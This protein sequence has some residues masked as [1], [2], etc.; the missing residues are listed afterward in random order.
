MCFTLQGELAIW[1]WLSCL[2]QL[3]PTKFYGLFLLFLSRGRL[4]Y[5]WY[6]CLSIPY[7]YA[8]S[9]PQIWRKL[10]FM[11]VLLK[12][13]QS[14]RCSCWDHISFLPYENTMQRWQPALIQ[15]P[16]WHQL[17]SKNAYTLQL[18]VVCNAGNTRVQCSLLQR[19]RGFCL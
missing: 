10:S 4:T 12:L 8:R 6:Q 13:P 14:C 16:L 11:S 2:A 7:Y 5:H 17:F 15:E 18:V 3:V 19:I 9:C 1:M